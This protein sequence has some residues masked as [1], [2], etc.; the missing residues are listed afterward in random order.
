[1]TGVPMGTKRTILVIDDDQSVC[2]SI[3]RT[4]SGRGYEVYAETQHQKGIEK[5]GEI[6]PDLIFIGLL[7]NTSNGLKVSKEIHALEELRRVPVVMIISYQGELDPKYTRAIGIVDVLIKPLKESDI[8]VKT[9]AVLGPSEFTDREEETMSVT[10]NS[11][12]TAE[13]AEP[14]EDYVYNLAAQTAGDVFNREVENC[15]VPEM[16]DDEKPQ[17]EEPIHAFAEAAS[18]G[19]TLTPGGEPP[20]DLGSERV[21]G[22]HGEQ[23]D[24]E[25]SP[26]EVMQDEVQDEI[27]APKSQREDRTRSFVLPPRKSSKKKMA[28]VLSLLLLII[29]GVITYMGLRFFSSA[30]NRSAVPPVAR[31]SLVRD[32]PDS[33]QTAAESLAGEADRQPV[34]VKAGKPAVP[35]P[36]KKVEKEKDYDAVAKKSAVT[37]EAKSP[38]PQTKTVFSVQIGFFG[39]L[40]NAESLAEKMKQKGYPVSLK[41]EENV[42]GKASYRVV[43]GKFSSR[44]EAAEQA[45]DILRKE[46]MKAILYKE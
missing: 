14:E 5:A 20:V 45:A 12:I 44:K 28:L 10:D 1:M 9:E 39:N 15:A 19:E 32:I 21:S 35:A 41:K 30:K 37:Q 40:K 29:A 36:E 22:Q 43:V 25:E 6:L 42:G 18:A 13:A 8:I 2:D 26:R 3:S 33:Q 46:G 24:T 7:L 27:K 31:E 11:E 38:A 34:D 17:I 23:T 16:T 4:L